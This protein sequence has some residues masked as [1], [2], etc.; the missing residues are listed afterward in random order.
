MK[1]L[2]IIFALAGGY[3]VFRMFMLGRPGLDLASAQAAIQSG[4]A[5]LVDV[6]EP[7]EWPSG[8]A[9]QAALLPLSDLRGS[10]LQWHAFLQKHPGKKLLLYCQSGTR[11]GLAAAQLRSEGFD[12]INVGSFRAWNRAGWPVRA[13]TDLR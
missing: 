10:K 8:V 7:G 5:V 2:W 1:I 11:S 12:A 4:A 6:R 3:L 13:P 9:Q